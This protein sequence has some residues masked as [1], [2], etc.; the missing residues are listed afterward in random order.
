M[1]KKEIQMKEC[2]INKLLKNCDSRY[3]SNEKEQCQDCSLGNNCPKNSN[4][5]CNKCLEYIHFPDR[6]P[7]Q[8]TYDCPNLA[9]FYTCKHAYK[10][11]SELVYALKELKLKTSKNLKVLSF[12]CGPCT[13]LLALD[14][15]KKYDIY[16]YETLEYKGIDYLEKVWSGIHKALTNIKCSSM[17]LDFIYANMVDFISELAECEWC[18]NLVIFQYVLSDLY[19]NFNEDVVHK[20]LDSFSEYVNFNLCDESY[21]ILNDINHDGARECF[22]YLY[23]KLTT[24]PFFNQYNQTKGYFKNPNNKNDC[25]VYGRLFKNSRLIF[26]SK[27]FDKYKTPTVKSCSSAQMVIEKVVP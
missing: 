8:K 25:Y 1:S 3:T 24:D 19:K 15:L 4:S 2:M 20:F 13:D 5:G 14:F 18:P 7:K 27:I 12:G 11:T 10:L 17:T 23:K 21:I 22:D 26:T 16:R 6:S 9:D